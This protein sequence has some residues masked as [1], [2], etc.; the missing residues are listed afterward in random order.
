MNRFLMIDGIRGI[1]AV[2]I[3]LYHIF[4][5]G[6]LAEAAAT[7]LPEAIEVVIANG[8]MAVQWFLV[9][10]GFGSALTT[11]EAAPQ[12]GQIPGY[13]GRRILRLGPIYWISISVC[14]LLTIAAIGGWNDR[15]LNPEYP[16]LPLLLAHLCFLQDVLGYEPLNTGI[17]YVAIAV[18]LDVAFLGLLALATT[19][20]T[21]IRRERQELPGGLTLVACFAPLTLWS[22][23]ASIHESSTEVWFHHFFCLF[24]LGTLLGWA[25]AGRISILWY[26]GYAAIV[27]GQWYWYS[28]REVVVAI[29]ASFAIY[30]AWR[31]HRLQTWLGW[32]ALQYLGR[33]SYSLFLIDYPIS[34]LVA[35]VGYRWTGERAD[36][37][38][39]WL[40]AGFLASVGV[41]HVLYTFVERPLWEWGR[42]FGRRA[43]GADPNAT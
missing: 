31:A 33:I 10:T 1:G 15:S 9:I 37:A 5:Y 28:S 29:I 39:A 34:W 40:I 14:A 35:R 23:F 24:M 2:A 7:V 16:T 38:L 41:A 22:L 36:A 30:G 8:W 32:S 6:P 26:F 3:A 20:S 43:E 12:F 19:L 18:Q 11:R 27:V 4:R 13:L 25:I 42:R 21:W 17:W